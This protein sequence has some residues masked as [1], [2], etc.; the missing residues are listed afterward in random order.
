MKNEIE[1]LIKKCKA[2]QN[3][4]FFKSINDDGFSAE[5]LDGLQSLLKL[6]QT[7]LEIT[8]EI[9]QESIKTIEDEYVQRIFGTFTNT[10]KIKEAILFLVKF[11]KL[12]EAQIKEAYRRGWDDHLKESG[13]I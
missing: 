5:M 11:A 2:R 6:Y 4:I 12:S 3:I 8:P 7:Q 13:G 10:E 9:I 1:K